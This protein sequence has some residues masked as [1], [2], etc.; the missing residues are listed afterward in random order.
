MMR[1]V[2][3]GVCYALLILFIGYFS[4]LPVYRPLA[5]EEAV[6]IL[7]QR[8]AG[9]LLGE[10]RQ[11]SAEEL[12]QLPPNMRIAES[13]PRERSPLLIE[14]LIDGKPY[15]AEW[16]P[17]AGFQKDGMASLYKRFRVPAAETHIE[18][19]MKDHVDSASYD[20]ALQR[21]VDL[22]PNRVLVIDFKTAEKAFV[23]L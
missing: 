8:H 18:V 9:R 22:A 19:R 23:I 1:W 5:D 17:P 13:C 15:H 4:N 7:T 11:R 16:L 14:L 12:A 21:D 20:Y 3:Q 6:I 2:A 10:C